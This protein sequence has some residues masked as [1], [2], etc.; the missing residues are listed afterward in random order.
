MKPQD[1]DIWLKNQIDEPEFDC[2]LKEI[3]K[4]YAM[5]IIAAMQQGETD[6]EKGEAAALNWVLELP[7]NLA[8]PIA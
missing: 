3:E 7:E 4:R 1:F 2:F 6:F 5:K 8:K